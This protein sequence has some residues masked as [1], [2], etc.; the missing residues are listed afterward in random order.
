MKMTT[1]HPTLR[2]NFLKNNLHVFEK[3][4]LSCFSFLVIVVF[5]S[6]SVTVSQILIFVLIP[7]IYSYIFND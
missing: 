5:V 1:H 3:Q 7:T 4:I 6:C 2:S